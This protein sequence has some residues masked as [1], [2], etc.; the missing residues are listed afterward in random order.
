MASKDQDPRIKKILALRQH[1]FDA[2]LKARRSSEKAV[3]YMNNIQWTDT[4]IDHCVNLIKP[5]LTYNIIIPIFA[6]LKGN[7]ELMRRRAKIKPVNN[8]ETAMSDILQGR[9]NAIVD[10]QDY[11]RH[12]FLYPLSLGTQSVHVFYWMEP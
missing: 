9:W 4:D 1:S 7:E 5:Y 12:L 8:K 6:A 2:F 3:R 11:K 10:E